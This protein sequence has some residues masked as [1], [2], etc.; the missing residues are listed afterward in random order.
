MS[1]A[2]ARLIC[3]RAVREVDGR[4]GWRS[5]PALNWVSSLVMTDEQALDLVRHV[6]APVLTFTAI[7]ESPWASRAKLQARREAM[8]GG[9]HE[10]VDGN[11][12]FHMDDPGRIA[13][14][15]QD[16]IIEHD[17]PQARVTHEQ[18]D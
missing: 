15:I 13:E 5:D 17:Q 9:R 10:S 16:F 11:H 3:T 8:A 12:H 1:A 4:F 14:T 18:A 7:E 6:E 2:A